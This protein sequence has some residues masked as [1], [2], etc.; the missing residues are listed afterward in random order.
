MKEFFELLSN[1]NTRRQSTCRQTARESTKVSSL[2]HIIGMDKL[3]A[4][5]L[6]TNV[7]E[8]RWAGTPVTPVIIAET[9]IYTLFEL[10]ELRTERFQQLHYFSFW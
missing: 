8:G 4:L 6:K 1:R 9:G 10:L 5:P 3:G 2:T 7:G